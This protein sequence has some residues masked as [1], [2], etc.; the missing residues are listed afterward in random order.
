IKPGAGGLVPFEGVRPRPKLPGFDR[1]EPPFT[2]NF[3]AGGVNELRYVLTEV[4]SFHD[5]TALT[6]LLSWALMT[7]IKAEIRAKG[8]IAVFPF[9]AIEAVSGSGKTT[10][11]VKMIG[12]LTGYALGDVQPTPAD[13]RDKLAAFRSGFLH[14]DDPKDLKRYEEILRVAATEGTITKRQDAE[15]SMSAHMT[16]GLLLTGEGLGI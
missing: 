7:I 15:H 4:L 13:L 5:R 12:E 10:G 8:K 9:F 14:F 16:G 11:A 1:Y 2:Y 6:A 3:A